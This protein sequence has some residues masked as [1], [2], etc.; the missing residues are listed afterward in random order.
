MKVQKG[1]TKFII[2]LLWYVDVKNTPIKLQHHTS[3]TWEVIAF[4]WQLDLE[5]VLK[6]QKGHTKINIEH[7][8]DFDVENTTVKLQLDISNL[9]RAIVFTRSFQMLSTWK[10]KK[11][12]QR[13]TSSLAEILIPISCC[14]FIWIT[15]CTATTWYIQFL[16]SYCIHKSLDL[17]LYWKF[18]KVIQRSRSN[19]AEILMR[20]TSLPVKLQH[21]A[22]TFW[23]IIIFKRNCKMMQFEHDVV[24]KVKK[25]SQRSTCLRFWCAKYLYKVTT[26][27]M[28]FPNS[29]CV[30]KTTWPWASLK[31][32]KWHTKFIIEL[33]QYGDVKNTP[34]KLQH[35][36]S[37]TWEVITFTR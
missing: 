33:L 24:Q 4:T 31:V 35:Y 17:G 2:E 29:Y 23:V 34:I 11:I 36:T 21:G 25:V 3:N 19:L 32:K 10:F 8:Q 18:K 30:H 12:T 37:N 22:G 27:C 6:V 20:R 28:Q 5:L 14:N 1:H 9:W 13:S 26:W 15:P 7:V 16:R